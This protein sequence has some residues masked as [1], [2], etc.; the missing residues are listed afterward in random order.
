MPEE[1]CS[2]DRE[3]DCLGLQKANMLEAQMKEWREAARKT[4][5]EL[6]DRTRDLE[7]SDA[8]REEQ[9]ETIIEKLDDLLSWKKDEQAAPGERWKAIV[10]KIIMLIVGAVVAFALAKVGL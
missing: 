10:D 5:K 9:Y 7:K 2:F 8:K 4:H 3:R 1:K 6:Y